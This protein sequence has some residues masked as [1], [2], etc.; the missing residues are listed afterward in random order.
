MYALMIGVLGLIM[1]Y[2]KQVNLS[3]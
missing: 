2:L 1:L 3:Y